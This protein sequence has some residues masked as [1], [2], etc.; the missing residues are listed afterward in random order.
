MRD[1][2]RIP[3]YLVS[4]LVL[5]CATWVV[6]NK[7]VRQD[8]TARLETGA[9]RA[10][11]LATFFE[12]ET[13]KILAI[14]DTLARDTVRMIQTRTGMGTAAW[15]LDLDHIDNDHTSH[16]MVVG[17]DGAVMA[18]SEAFTAP[19]PQADKLYFTTLRDDPNATVVI[20]RPMTD[21]M[22]GR[23]IVK[24]ARRI[25]LHDNQFGGIVVVGINA[26]EFI[27]FTETLDFGV[28]SVARL[29]GTD[30]TMRV[31]STYGDI[32]PGADTS[33]E[34]LWSEV[35]ESSIGTYRMAGATPRLAAYRKIPGY[36][37]IAEVALAESDLLSGT[38][39]FVR[40]LRMISALISAVI[41][42]LIAML[43]YA[44]ITRGRL[45]DEINVRR[46]AEAELEAANTDLAQFAYAASHDLKAPVSSIKGLLEFC[47]EDLEA[48]DTDEVKHN[49]GE[50]IDIAE[51]AAEKVESLLRLARSG[52][53]A[54]PK[55]TFSLRD[56]VNAIWRDQT[57]NLDDTCNLDIQINGP[58]QIATER[59]TLQV[60][61]ENIIANAVRYRDPA[62]PTSQINLTANIGDGTS[63]ITIADNGVGIPE[64][65]QP[66][67]FEMFTRADDRAGHGLGLALVK[68]NV[69]RLGAKITLASTF[70]KG[71][72]FKLTL[73]GLREN[74]T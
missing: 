34:K 51:R 36:P 69:E 60:I 11:E 14:A 13:L 33:G 16:V 62:K 39:E 35:R 61:L 22:T 53:Q 2:T 28:D 17:R 42:T 19:G 55:E 65:E 44:E 41:L 68:K 18:H 54:T 4:A 67:V 5:I 45:S 6:T 66:R 40:P 26:A 73:H 38:R 9:V 52:N 8:A 21:L 43:C 58:E 56:M 48:G 32:G 74:P 12:A 63:T 50:A 49:L 10:A 64:K 72:E 71:T 46:A 30:G 47:Q 24:L 7:L 57:A 25:Q 59:A 20:S 37:L 1:F 3:I 29:I 31:G 23:M 15:R 27:D 70:G